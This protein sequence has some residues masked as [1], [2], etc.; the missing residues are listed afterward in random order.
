MKL[1]NDLKN[2]MFK[3]A[4]NVI[5]YANGKFMLLKSGVN[6]MPKEIDEN[7]LLNIVKNE[8]SVVIFK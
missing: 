8:E 3:N 5:E 6:W 1:T 2:Q 7:E 4:D